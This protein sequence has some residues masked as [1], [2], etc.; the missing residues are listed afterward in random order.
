MRA[1]ALLWRLARYRLGTYLLSGLTASFMFYVSPLVPGLIVQHVFDALTRHAAAGFTLPTL[2]ALIV[3]AGLVRAGVLL[4]AV[5]F[6]STMGLTAAALL[7]HN[8]FLRIMRR[9][10]AQPVPFSAGESISRFRDDV[11]AITRFLTW[12]LDP[13]GQTMATLVALGVLIRVEPLVTVAVLVPLMVV[14][15]TVQAA[16]KRIHRYRKANQ[17]EIGNVTGFLGE[18]FG[19]VTAVKSAGAERRVTERFEEI[20]ERRRVAALNDVLFSQGLR[21]FSTNAGT[22]GTGV[23]LLVIAGKMKSG[24]FTVGEFALFVSYMGWLSTIASMFGNFL[25]L[26]RQTLVSLERLIVLLQGAP[27]GELVRHRDIFLRGPF[28]AIPYLPK[29]AEDRLECLDVTNL[30]YT[31]ATTGRG[32]AGI[33]LHIPR[34]SFTVITG[35]VGSGKSTVLRVL[36]GLLTRDGGVIR[37]NGHEV[38]DPASH[39]VAPRSAYTGQVPRLFTDSL[40][41]NILLGLPEDRVD[42]PGAVEAA[43]MTDDVAQFDDG[44]DVR[45]GPRGV[46]LSGGQI[47]RAA[48][49]RMFVRAP[50]LLVIDDV[51]SAL[52]VDTERELWTRLSERGDSTCLVVSH[53]R[54]ALQRATHIIILKD[55]RI[56]A[57]GTLQHL[58]ETSDEMRRLWHGTSTET[59]RRGR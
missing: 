44:L 34:G 28:P 57:E 26:Y 15:V 24:Q 23:L 51:S 53:R 21:S 52:D 54:P 7:R 56:E 32:I 50:E 47:Q 49:A 8:L 36:L 19:A 43:V 35:R 13:V 12:T 9:P 37:W 6:E 45:I 4:A 29:T 25:T 31:Y 5:A 58:L 17:E 30:S 18:I 1:P 11:E 10:G 16:A 14:L 38:P 22:V 41:D 42:L 48:A 2:I 59:G 20:N 39:F 46:R 40:R 33:D 27:E 3:A 55:G